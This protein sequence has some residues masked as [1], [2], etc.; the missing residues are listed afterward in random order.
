MT[1]RVGASPTSAADYYLN[2]Q[3]EIDAFL[4]ILNAQVSVVEAAGP[5]WGNAAR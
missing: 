5:R 3:D 1:I 4:S 2:D